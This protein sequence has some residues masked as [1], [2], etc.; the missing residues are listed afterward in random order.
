MSHKSAYVGCILILLTCC[1]GGAFAQTCPVGTAPAVANFV[2]HGSAS[3]TGVSVVQLSWSPTTMGKNGSAGY[4]VYVQPPVFDYA[5][6][7]AVL[8]SSNQTDP[9]VINAMPPGGVDGLNGLGQWTI[10][11]PANGKSLSVPNLALAMP[12]T[13]RIMTAD[14]AALYNPL[15]HLCAGTAVIASAITYAAANT[16]VWGFAD[17]HTHPFADDAY[18][19]GNALFHG[20]AFGPKDQVVGHDTANPVHQAIA[21]LHLQNAMVPLVDP[22][23]PTAGWPDF[24]KYPSFNLTNLDQAMYSDWLYRAF[25]GG[26]RLMVAHAVNNELM[27]VGSA[28]L[29]FIGSAATCDDMAAV[30]RQLSDA[31]AMETYLNAQCHATA[32]PRCLGPNKGWLHI[33]TSPAEARQTINGGQLA[34]VLG[35]EVDRLFDCRGSTTGWSDNSH[36]C[37][38]L[39]A[40]TQQWITTEVQKYQNAGV[41]HVFIVHLSDSAFGGMAL[42]DAG[43]GIPW[44]V[45]NWFENGPQTDFST[46]TCPSTSPGYT[47]NY[48]TV[49]QNA[50]GGSLYNVLTAGF[51][52]AGV[53][54]PNLHQGYPVPTCDARGLTAVGK[55]LVT[56]LIKNGIMIDMDHMSQATWNDLEPMLYQSAQQAGQIRP[57]YWPIIAG[58]TGPNATGTS[59]SERDL[60]D[61]QLTFLRRSGGLPAAGI[62]VG[63]AAGA[64][65]YQSSQG[66]WIVPNCDNSSS[67]YAG[68][69]LYLVDA[70]GGPGNAAVALASD[71]SF[72]SFLSPRFSWGGKGELR[73]G[74][75]TPE[76]NNGCNGNSGQ[77]STQDFPVTFTQFS[78]PFN[79]TPSYYFSAKAGP[80]ANGPVVYLWTGERDYSLNAHRL[81]DFNTDGWAHVG[82]YPEMIQDLQNIGVTQQEIAPLYASAERYIDAWTSYSAG[83]GDDTGLNAAAGTLN[84]FHCNDQVVTCGTQ[85]ACLKVNAFCSDGK[86]PVGEVMNI[87]GG[88]PA[89]RVCGTCPTPPACQPDDPKCKNQHPN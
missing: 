36:D 27:C 4:V 33:V 10:T 75:H 26:L 79:A 59:K 83:G 21:G 60:N 15:T 84:P 41:R 65:N 87:C 14:A 30:D 53:S 48:N 78:H 56:I 37:T 67:A 24:D 40:A 5:Q 71:Q 77:A 45:N 66:T 47:F 52:L 57:Q 43:N 20:H 81:W 64:V 35:I 6:D 2:A 46:Q 22:N 7:P 39:N 28:G 73:T 34:I 23:P 25:L 63:A 74:W 38:Q 42:Y 88:N 51:K 61:E 31:R 50:N 55:F 54:L 62:E 76:Y 1:A 49:I 18:D 16:Q 17:T 9:L 58:H 85:K 72:N 12:Y 32:P 3:G 11:V 68:G 70:M 8:N 19:Q 13:F 80:G 82:L 69:Y 29:G 89:N 86:C 44:S